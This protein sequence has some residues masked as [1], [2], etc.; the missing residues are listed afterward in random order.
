MKLDFAKSTT[1]EAV[2]RFCR[3]W[4]SSAHVLPNLRVFR[5]GQEL[6]ADEI[7][8]VENR[9]DDD[10]DTQGMGGSVYRLVRRGEPLGDYLVDAYDGSTV[11]FDSKRVENLGARLRAA[12]KKVGWTQGEVADWMRSTIRSIRLTT[13]SRWERGIGP[14]LAPYVDLVERFIA[15]AEGGKLGEPPRQAG[16]KEVSEPTTSEAGQ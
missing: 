16:E 11:V 9:P 8:L 6:Q 15:E 12:R 2:E 10:P 13:V 7:I 3:E 1:A 14:E 4:E 5:D